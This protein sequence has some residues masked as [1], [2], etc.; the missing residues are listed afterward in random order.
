MGIWWHEAKALVACRKAGIP[1]D[2]MISLGRQSLEVPVWYVR[3]CFE[4]YDMLPPDFDAVMAAGTRHA[5]P[6]FRLLGGKQVDAID[7]SDY[8]G[9]NVIHDMNKPLPDHLKGRYDVVFD[10]GS[11]E[12]I[13][14]FPTAVRNCMEMV[15]VGGHLM[16]QTPANNQ[17]GHGFYQFSPELFF[18][19]LSPANG[20]EMV[21]LLAEEY[22]RG[23]RWFEVTDPETVRSRV[24]LIC[25]SQVQLFV[26]ARRTA[27]VPLFRT[28]PLQSDYVQMWADAA[29]A[30]TS[31]A[32]AS[33]PQ[34]LKATLARAADNLVPGLVR[35]YRIRHK[36]AS[37]YWDNRKFFR[38]VDR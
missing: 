9:A 15:K 1:F 30:G 26:C 11:L 5:D 17:F 7:Y 6:F 36:M 38:Q 25:S 23:G 29:A 21:R 2:T 16:I 12:H 19:I 34:K 8:E 33:R 22:V 28:P 20:F 31:S 37:M 4:L 10:G 32:S 27:D 14:N 35:R 24:N 3:E 18:R 13:F